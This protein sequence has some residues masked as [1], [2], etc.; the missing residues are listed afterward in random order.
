MQ[1]TPLWSGVSSGSCYLRLFK[2]PYSYLRLSE[3]LQR[4]SRGPHSRDGAF[5]N[6]GTEK[7]QY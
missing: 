3:A 5:C 1:Q 2:P 6:A 7:R 4:N